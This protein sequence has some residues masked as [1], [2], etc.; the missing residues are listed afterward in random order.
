MSPDLPYEKLKNNSLFID[1]RSE[2]EFNESHIP[3]AINIPLFTNAERIEIGTA[4]KQASVDQARR[5][6]VK[7]ASN[8]MS[9]TFE[10]LLELRG[11]HNQNLVAYCARGGYRST[12]FSSAFSSIGIRVLKLDG[13]YKKYRQYVM[14]SLPKYNESIEYI[15]IHGNTG[16]G[17]TE[18]LKA[19]K[20]S[21]IE[22]LDL[23]NAANHRGSLLGGIGLGK[24]KSQKQFESNLIEQMQEIKAG[25]V[26]VEAESR[27]IGNVM[28]PKYIH[29]KMKT[30]MH[31]F[32]SGDMD[33]RI[34][35][36]KKDY[37]SKDN[38]I[39]ESLIS[40]DRLKKYISIEK[41]NYL[42]EQIK[43]ENIEVVIKELMQTYYDPLYTNKSDE[44]EYL[45]KIE[46][47][48][49]VEDTADEIKKWYLETIL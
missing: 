18:I 4:Y 27:R 23:E 32:I 22:I 31:I 33:Y 43:A 6:G 40:I 16:T 12:F 46:N 39:E 42:I 29:D 14:D 24:C 20:N 8:K 25:Y 37:T 5:L 30:G 45:L 21:G 28:V 7:Y 41:I 1:V 11:D 9:D 26:F 47:I 13:G 49:N 35:I 34:N 17:K 3:D 48:N 36:I 19:L 2:D 10:K 15:V 38:W 44:Y